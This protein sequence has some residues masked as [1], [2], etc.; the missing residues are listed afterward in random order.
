MLAIL[1][2]GVTINNNVDFV[3]QSVLLFVAIR[4]L[5]AASI[6]KSNFVALTE[7]A[8]AVGKYAYGLLS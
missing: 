8:V 6:C 7:C 3:K 5:C 2:T 4:D 1:S